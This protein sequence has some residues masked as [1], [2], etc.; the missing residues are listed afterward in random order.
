MF[1]LRA[2]EKEIILLLPHPKSILDL[3]TIDDGINTGVGN[4][5][6]EQGSLDFWIY[7]LR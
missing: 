1:I 2:A 6:Y 7:L 4:S 5:K 3:H